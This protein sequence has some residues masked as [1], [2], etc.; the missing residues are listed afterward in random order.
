[1]RMI[2]FM[3]IAVLAT[4]GLAA[5]SS[6]PVTTLPAGTY[7]YPQDTYYLHVPTT[8][9]PAGTYNYP[10]DTYYSGPN[11]QLPLSYGNCNTCGW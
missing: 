8:Y 5:C 9:I 10:A 11:T 7:T 4:L 3:L 1:M 2:K 6:Y